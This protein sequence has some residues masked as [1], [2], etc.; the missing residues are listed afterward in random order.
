MLRAALAVLAVTALSLSGP[1]A[2]T[3]QAA[4]SC[5]SFIAN[6]TIV[7]DLVVPP[8]AKCVLSNVTVTG[9]VTVGGSGTRREVTSSSKMLGI[10]PGA[11]AAQVGTSRLVSSPSA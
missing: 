4:T 10:A 5:T 6:T 3:T 8:G 7:G 9:S 1:L 11:A 2:P